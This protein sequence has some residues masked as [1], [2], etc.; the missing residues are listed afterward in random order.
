MPIESSS[1]NLSRWLELAQSLLEQPTAALMEHLPQ[2][3]V[4]EFAAAR[5]NLKL[6]ED[7]AGNLRVDY[8]SGTA[9]HPPLA[10][11]AHLDHPGF[12]VSKINGDIVE[13]LFLGSVSGQHAIQGSHV[14]FFEAGNPE[15]LGN[16]ELIER[17]ERTG[18]LKTA[19]AKITSGTAAAGGFAMWAFPG[20]SLEIESSIPAHGRTNPGRIVTRCCDD[21]LG[22]AAA[23]CVLDEISKLA[24][25]NVALTG[26][27]TRA[28]EIGFLGTMEAIR[29]GTLPKNACVLSLECSK[30]F[31]HAPQGGGVIVRVGDAASIFDTGLTH[32]LALAAKNRAE[33]DPTFKFQRK[34]MDGGVCEATPFCAHGYR[35]SGLALPLGNYHNQAFDSHDQP[36]MGPESVKVDD[37]RCEIEL[38]IELALHPELLDE[39]HDKVS[40]RLKEL[41]IKAQELLKR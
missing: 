40:P 6:S 11:V 16:G 14:E 26:L 3:F 17:T 7:A 37:F 23:L 25:Q 1:P 31:P 20:F 5:P 38:L 18:A 4:R 13:L 15:S 30:A 22:A 27:F 24:P 28:E 35:A 41:A 32:A 29:L 12:H 19:S 9:S 33:R 8:A 36:C 39:G 10:M 34:L 2:K 21:L